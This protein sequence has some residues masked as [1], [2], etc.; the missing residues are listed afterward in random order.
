M[1]GG[2]VLSFFPFSPDRLGDEGDW[3]RLEDGTRIGVSLNNR[4]KLK[5][6]FPVLATNTWS[7]SIYS[8]TASWPVDSSAN[9][10]C[11]TLVHEVIVPGLNIPPQELAAALVDLTENDIAELIMRIASP[12][13]EA[14]QSLL[15]RCFETIE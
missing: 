5:F 12:E 3:I 13:K 4:K 2:V 1:G 14:I 10:S 8:C 15:E 9:E 6:L 7:K 11:K